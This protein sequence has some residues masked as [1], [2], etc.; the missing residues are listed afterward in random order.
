[1]IDMPENL[2]QPEDLKD[3]PADD[4]HLETITGRVV[5]IGVNEQQTTEEHRGLSDVNQRRVIDALRKL[6]GRSATGSNK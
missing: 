2:T 1:M 5:A 6:R 3:S 4:A